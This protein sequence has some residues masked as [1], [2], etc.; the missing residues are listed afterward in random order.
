M[1]AVQLATPCRQGRLLITRDTVTLTR[2]HALGHRPWWMV[3]RAHVVGA[4][5][6]RE[7]GVVYLLICTG[8]GAARRV[9]PL[10]SADALRVVDMLGYAAGVS[11]FLSGA[12]SAQSAVKMPCAG[13]HVALAGGRLTF[14]PLFPWR[15]ATAWALPLDQI[16]GA[17]SVTRIGP[18]RLHDL[19]IHSMDGKVYALRRLRPEHALDLSRLCGHLYA[20]LPAEPKSQREALEYHITAKPRPLPVGLPPPITITPPRQAQTQYQARQQSQRTPPHPQPPKRRGVQRELDDFW[21]Q[22]RS[23]TDRFRPLAGA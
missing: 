1:D 21:S 18:H 20:A 17:S 15:R 6:A 13:G 10:A 4:S 12:A 9:D 7:P 22:Q 3:A 2:R 19:A 16:L 5:V 14:H 23:A 11:P 8:D